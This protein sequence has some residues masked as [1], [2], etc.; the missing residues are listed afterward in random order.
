MVWNG[1][2]VRLYLIHHD[3]P[4]EQLTCTPYPL[5]TLEVNKRGSVFDYPIED[6]NLAG[7]DP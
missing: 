5:P 2:E 4:R 1:G 6:L 7:Y 3:P